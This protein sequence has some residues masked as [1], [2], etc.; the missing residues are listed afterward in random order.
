[1]ATL[2]IAVEPRPLWQG[3]WV[4]W[5]A[6]LVLI[7]VVCS[8]LWRYGQQV[9][10]QAERAA[11]QSTL[12]A[13]RTALVLHQLQSA[14]VPTSKTTPLRPADTQLPNPFTLL[15]QR[16]VNYAGEVPAALL[17]EVAGGKWVFDRR[18]TCVGYK[19]QES[20]TLDAPEGAQALWFVLEPGSSAMQLR[21]M[22]AYVWGGQV[23]E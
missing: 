13:L 16:P 7:V 18:C 15:Q 8:V 1:M 4:E 2:H 22:Q 17:Q 20:A 19:P 5:S 23:L 11:V 3:R 14:L 21:P 12:G 6:L 10:A 9:R